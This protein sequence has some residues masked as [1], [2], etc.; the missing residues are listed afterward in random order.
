LRQF[1]SIVI[2]LN[3][4][5]KH[6]KK[7]IYR[8]TDPPRFLQERSRFLALPILFDKLSTNSTILLDDA[9]RENEKQLVEDW[10]GFLKT[11]QVKR[12]ITIFEYFAKG[13]AL[14]EIKK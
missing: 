9:N 7:H 5:K 3:K 12:S 13:L 8:I 6:E 10:L 14:I 4:Q 11:N 2:T 1:K